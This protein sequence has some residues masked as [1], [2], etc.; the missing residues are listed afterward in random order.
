M[1][2]PTTHILGRL[3]SELV[4]FLS[5]WCDIAN[6]MTL[7][8]VVDSARFVVCVGIGRQYFQ[9]LG[10]GKDVTSYLPS[11]RTLEDGLDPCLGV[12]CVPGIL[13]RAFCLFHILFYSSIDFAIETG[14]F[15]KCGWYFDRHVGVS[16]LQQMILQQRRNH[17]SCVCT[18]SS[19][20]PSFVVGSQRLPRS[21]RINR[22]KSKDLFF[23][24]LLLHCYSI[25]GLFVRRTCTA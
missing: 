6:I 21:Q 2:C 7:M 25:L 24:V 3:Y 9:L 4:S 19:D 5:I 17:V 12:H 8:R 18:V 20:T 15:T 1:P 22:R 23:S 13:L 10:S 16:I 14:G 11:P